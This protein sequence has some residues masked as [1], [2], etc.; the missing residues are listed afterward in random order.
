MPTVYLPPQLR[1]FAEGNAAISVDGKTVEE[2][3]RSLEGI[4]PRLAGRLR[5]GDDLKP[6][7][8]VSV[9]GSVGPRR[10]LQSVGPDSEIHF[11]P[12]IGGG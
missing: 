5:D 11:L 8:T 12:A 10:L 9:D 3:I 4:H 6:A 2:V 7:L 1:S